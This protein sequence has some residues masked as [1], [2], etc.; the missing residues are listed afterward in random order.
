MEN[1]KVLNKTVT[2]SDA[3]LRASKRIVAVAQELVRNNH[4]PC[5]PTTDD[6]ADIIREEIASS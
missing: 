5:A 3:A 2:E 6:W 1:E 4:I